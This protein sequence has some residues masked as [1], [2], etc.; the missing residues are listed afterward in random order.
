MSTPM[1]AAD[2]PAVIDKIKRVI[3][4]AVWPEAVSGFVRYQRVKRR[5]QLADTWVGYEFPQ[6]AE[7]V[8]WI[9]RGTDGQDLQ[10][11]LRERGEEG[12]E[13]VDRLRASFEAETLRAICEGVPGWRDLP[14]DTPALRAA[15]DLRESYEELAVG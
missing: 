9:A 2:E 11:S 12:P 10:L 5:L 13:V 1:M 4:R 14:R 3:T 6:V 8:R 15:H 7:T